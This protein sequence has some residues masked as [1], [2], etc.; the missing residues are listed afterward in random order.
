MKKLIKELIKLRKEQKQTNKK[1]I[2]KKIDKILNKHYDEL[3]KS[4]D[5]LYSY[6]KEKFFNKHQMGEILD[7]CKTLEILQDRLGDITQ[8]ANDILEDM[9]E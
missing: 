9:W 8:T 4:S 7:L 3:D 2:I 5:I 6:Y 1:Q